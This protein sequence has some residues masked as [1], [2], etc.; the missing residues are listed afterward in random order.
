[1]VPACVAAHEVG[2]EFADGTRVA[3]GGPMP[4]PGHVMTLTAEKDPQG[5]PTTPILVSHGGGGGSDRLLDGLLV[6][7][8]PGAR[9]DEH[10]RGVGDAEI[11]ETMVTLDATSITQSAPSAVTLWDPDE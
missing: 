4:F 11:P 6:L 8:T 3:E 2:F 10:L 7:P 5:I 1:M 9:P